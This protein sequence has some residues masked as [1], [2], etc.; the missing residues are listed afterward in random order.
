[1]STV[2]SASG[3]ARRPLR[4]PLRQ[5]VGLC[6]NCSRKAKWSDTKFWG[7]RCLYFSIYPIPGRSHTGIRLFSPGRSATTY[8]GYGSVGIVRNRPR[9]PP[10]Q[11]IPRS[12][13]P[14]GTGG[15]LSGQRLRS[16]PPRTTGPLPGKRFIAYSRYGRVSLI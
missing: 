9:V 6:S 15:S 5:K 11:K 2:S 4:Y 16:A 14:V 3:K 7:I 13:R 12:M 1:M 10:T 8:S